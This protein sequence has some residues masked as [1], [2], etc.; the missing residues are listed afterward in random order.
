[1]TP[2]EEFEFGCP[3]CEETLTVND[4]MRV[5]LIE[6]GCVLCGCGLTDGAFEPRR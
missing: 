5:A 2:Y 6:H 3:A 1:M 4:S